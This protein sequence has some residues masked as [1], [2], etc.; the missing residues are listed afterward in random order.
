MYTNVC[1]KRLLDANNRLTLK[2]HLEHSSAFYDNES[3]IFVF[4]RGY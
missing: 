3:R 1:F 2:V 4:R